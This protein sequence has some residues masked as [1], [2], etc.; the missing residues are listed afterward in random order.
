MRSTLILKLKIRNS[1]IRNDGLWPILFCDLT[2]L[3]LSNPEKLQKFYSFRFPLKAKYYPL[4]L[5]AIFTIINEFKIDLE[6]LCGIGYG[7]LYH[8]H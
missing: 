8:Y 2:L 1:G 6:I 7:F 5:L 3:C 4:V